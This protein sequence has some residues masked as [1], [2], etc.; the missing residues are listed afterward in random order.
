MKP[1]WLNSNIS[2]SR[3]ETSMEKFKVWK[4]KDSVYD[5]A[6][7]AMDSFYVVV[8]SERAAVIDTGISPGETIIPLIRRITDKPLVL[9]LTHAHLDHMHH[10][11]EFDEVYLCHDELQMSDEA[12]AVVGGGKTRE[13]LE[14]TKDM[15]TGSVISL[16]DDLLEIYK[17]PG[18]TPGTVVI[19]ESKYNMLFTGDAIGSGYGAWLHV[20]GALSLKEYYH[21][22]TGLMKWLIEKGGR[23]TFWGGHNSQQFQSSVMPGYNPLSIGLLADLIDLV[24]KIVRGEIVGHM[25][26]EESAVTRE[27]ALYASYG[28]AELYYDPNR[29]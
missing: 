3:K 10:M 18:H 11:N 9:V 25:A 26:R 28:R 15:Q 1:A 7:E 21:S 22:L 29:I 27:T 19:L 24:E 8:G 14:R 12:L 2:N 20:Y 23:M 16:G 5:L 6:D 17:V 13:D 4:V